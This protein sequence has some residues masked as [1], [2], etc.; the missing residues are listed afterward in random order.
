MSRSRAVG[1]EDTTAMKLS[2]TTAPTHNRKKWTAST[3]SS[4]TEKARPFAKFCTN[5]DK[6]VALFIQL[7]FST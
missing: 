2:A 7:F 3:L 4:I 5:C 6:H 1:V